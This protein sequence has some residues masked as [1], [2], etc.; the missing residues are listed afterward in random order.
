MKGEPIEI[1]TLSLS[2]GA[3]GSGGFL[4]RSGER[5]WAGACKLDA[6]YFWIGPL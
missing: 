1:V 4:A 2:K 6:C 5:V 3:H